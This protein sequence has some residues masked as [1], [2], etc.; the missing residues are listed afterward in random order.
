MK[1]RLVQS[2]F[3][4]TGLWR[5]HLQTYHESL[6]SRHT[7]VSNW[8]IW[9]RG[10]PRVLHFNCFNAPSWLIWKWVNY[11]IKIAQLK[12][13]VLALHISPHHKLGGGAIAFSFSLT[14]SPPFLNPTSWSFLK[15]FRSF[16]EK[17]KWEA[18]WE[19]WRTAYINF[20]MRQ[21]RPLIFC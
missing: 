19:N 13:L 5:T 7:T 16:R 20:F 18:R 3:R 9:H 6:E 15:I 1:M 12:G 21:L 14:R 17:H 4:V 10:V 8:P 11:I 2:H